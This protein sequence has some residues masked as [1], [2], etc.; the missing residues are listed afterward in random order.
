[1]YNDIDTVYVMTLGNPLAVKFIFVFLF[2]LMLVWWRSVKRVR[3]A[4]VLAHKKWQ[5][6]LLRGYSYKKDFFKS[7]LL[8]VGIVCLF[9]VLLQ[10]RWGKKDEHEQ[11]HG[12]DLFIALDISRSMLAQDVKPNRLEA[13]KDKIRTLLKKLSCER[14]G[15]IVFSGSA[16][17][18]CPLTQDYAAFYMFLDSLD[19]ETISSGTTALDAVLMKTI[20]LFESM[21][22][23]QNKLLVVLT[24]GEDFSSDLATV[25]QRASE[26]GLRIFTLGIGTPEGAPVP[27]LDQS[28]KQV[29]VQKDSKGSIVISRLNEG[30]L[31]T[32]AVDTGARYYRMSQSDS[33]ILHL[34]ADVERYEKELLDVNRV[35]ALE[36]RY[37]YFAAIS[38]VCF[39]IEWV[40]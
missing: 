28:G 10:P 37:Y 1:M 5:S 26:L 24:D 2:M 36:D 32:L 38:L 17:V 33:D 8:S 3:L 27:V 40:V 34:I 22:Q 19:V 11:Q 9:L 25:K 4:R 6:L 13:A 7:A 21:S 12:R 35:D 30:I 18:Q 29:G 20:Q 16:F 15:L 23:R 14:V 31:H 39:L